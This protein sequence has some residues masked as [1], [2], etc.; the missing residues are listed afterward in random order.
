[1][2]RRRRAR[3]AP[4]LVRGPALPLPRP[5][6][7]RSTA[8][9]PRSSPPTSCARKRATTGPTSPR[10]RPTAAT[11][12]SRRRARNFFGDDDPDP[13]GMYRAGGIFRF[14][15][16]TKALEKVA[17][18]SL[19]D[20]ATNAFKRR[21]AASPS[22]S[23]DGRYVAFAT[24]RAA[25]RRGHQRQHRRLRPRHGRPDRRTGGLRSRLGPR[26]RRRT[27]PIRGPGDLPGQQSGRRRHPRARDQRRRDAGRVRDD[28]SLRPAGERR[29]RCPRRPGLRPRP[30]D[31]H[32][33]PCLRRP[34]TL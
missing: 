17:D 32:D 10:S 34:A 28:G 22:I 33:D 15:L 31:Q 16:T 9:A 5:G 12:R 2:R 19:F 4:L 30:R 8:T 26:R 27:G 3:S 6:P 21:G 13:A 20:E 24:A 29:R 14:D 25:G 7:R 1:M 23:A 18:G 11:S